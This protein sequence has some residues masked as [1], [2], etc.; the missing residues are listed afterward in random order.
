MLIKKSVL[1]VLA[2][3]FLLPVLLIA[4][5]SSAPGD[6]ILQPV[7]WNRAMSSGNPTLAEFGRG[8]CIPC[9]EMKPILKALAEEYKGRLNVLI[10]DV[11]TYS[12]L[13][14]Q[15]G[16]M[17]IPTQIFFD[18][19]GKEVSRH[20]GLFPKADIIEELTKMGVE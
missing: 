2:A 11:D 15:Y 16:I 12:T 20:V 17:V 13:T 19:Y 3:L 8:T 10:I 5:R 7:S 6:S 9:K 14:R 18:K 1:S 4:C